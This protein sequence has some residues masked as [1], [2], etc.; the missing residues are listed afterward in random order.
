MFVNVRGKNNDKVLS[1]VLFFR[2]IITVP[3]LDVCVKAL[4][5]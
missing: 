4:I 1:G 5:S 3:N 2:Q